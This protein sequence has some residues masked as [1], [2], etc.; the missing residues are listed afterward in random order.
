M[1]LSGNQGSLLA[2]LR[3]MLSYTLYEDYGH[4]YAADIVVVQAQILH[5]FPVVDVL[6]S[7]ELKP[8]VISQAD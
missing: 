6:P 1:Q 8:S 2:T 4:A 7:Y 5:P 3:T